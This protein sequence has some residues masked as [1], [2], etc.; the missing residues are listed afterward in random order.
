[1][2]CN[3]TASEDSLACRNGSHLEGGNGIARL[4]GRLSIGVDEATNQSN[5]SGR[6]GI[7][8]WAIVGWSGSEWPHVEDSMD[9]D[10]ISYDR[11][12]LHDL[13]NMRW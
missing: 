9:I 12:A 2:L 6:L 11:A 7:P 10:N 1:M 3:E 5:S 8:L 13:G 4:P